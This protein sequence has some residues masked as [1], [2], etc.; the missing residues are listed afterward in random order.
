MVLRSDLNVT[1]I[2]D[3]IDEMIRYAM[4]C[5]QLEYMGLG[6]QDVVFSDI[7][8]AIDSSVNKKTVNGSF[9]DFIWTADHKLALIWI[10]ITDKFF[11]AVFEIDSRASSSLLAIWERERNVD[12]ADIKLEAMLL[13][14][15]YKL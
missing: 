9:V 14:M 11:T 12:K 3:R 10:T 7:G 6:G 13:A 4:S 1:F 5:M 15:G 2:D 8:Y